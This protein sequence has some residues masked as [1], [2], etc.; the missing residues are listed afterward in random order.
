M[1]RRG[2]DR[3][4]LGRLRARVMKDKDR[5]ETM[6]LQAPL[7]WTPVAGRR[8]KEPAVDVDDFFDKPEDDD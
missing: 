7:D 1:A 2:F 6:R 4:G 8:A 3:S 5:D